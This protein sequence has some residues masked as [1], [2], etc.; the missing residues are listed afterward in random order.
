VS[1]RALRAQNEA[2]TLFLNHLATVDTSGGPVTTEIIQFHLVPDMRKAF[3]KF[4]KEYGCT[5]TARKIT[6]EEQDKINKTRQSLMQFTSVKVTPAAQRAYLEKKPQ[7]KPTAASGS[8]TPLADSTSSTSKKRN[9][10]EASLDTSG[11]R[12]SALTTAKAKK[13]KA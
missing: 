10:T 2:K 9:A 1:G 5:A 12:S 4:V 11:A 3:N 13:A 7:K 8:T 6:R